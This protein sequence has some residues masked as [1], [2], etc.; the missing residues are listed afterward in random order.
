[1]VAHQ[2][3]AVP[4]RSHGPLAAFARDFAGFVGRRGWMA[5]ALLAGG[6]L[7]ESLGLLMLVPL[8][9]IILG[10]GTGHAWLDQAA[11]RIAAI[12]PG[13]SPVAQLAALLTIFALL[14]LIRAAVVLARDV[15]L[16][17]LHVGFVERLRMRTIRLLAGASWDTLSPLRHG[18]ITHVLGSDIQACGEAAQLSLLCL[19][20]G[21][22]LAA[23]MLLVLLLSPVLALIVLGL[24]GAGVLMVRPAL[25]RSRELGT[26]LTDTNLAL[27][28]STNQFLGGLKLALSQ[29]LT[30]SFVHE[31]QDSLREA[32]AQRIGFQRQRTI[33]QLSLTALAACV[34]G[35]T[36]LVGVAVTQS[37]PSTLIAFLVIL[38]RMNGPASQI[39]NAAQYVAHAM[40]AYLKIQELQAD[41]ASVQEARTGA[42]ADRA[43][44][45][46]ELRFD[47]VTYLHEERGGS[48]SGGVRGLSFSIRPGTFAGLVGASGAGKTTLADLLVGLYPPQ[49]GRIQVGGQALTGPALAAWRETISYVSQDPFLFHD[50]IRRNLLW[51]RP[52]ASDEELW[53]ALALAGADDLVRRLG[54]DTIVGERGMLVSGGERQRLAL[55]R[56]LLRRPR[57]LVLDE[58]TNAIDEPGEQAILARLAGLPDRPTIIMIAHRA[59]SLAFCDQLIRLRSGE[60]VQESS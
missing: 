3:I 8:L 42:S 44:P 49:G 41:L 25:R 13:D 58:A 17:R 22:M 14:M 30:G 36:L 18:R 50:T 60:L 27:V 6:A 19:V 9:G 54:L 39:Q 56:A 37:A 24:L 29:G 31:F 26:A 35:L 5:G 51:A 10:G 33:A 43:S 2:R 45:T 21:A 59:S 20:A 55:A 52:G 15:Q 47:N 12:A 28:S 7:L 1:M 40:P 4:D 16:A 46:G 38:A 34:A 23:Q 57:L 32:A 11:G 53:A 48:A